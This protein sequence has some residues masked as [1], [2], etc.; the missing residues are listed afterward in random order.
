ME[1]YLGTSKEG[2]GGPSKKKRKETYIGK[3]M[4]TEIYKGLEEPSHQWI[5]CNINPAKVS[6]TIKRQEQRI[7]TRAWKCDNGLVMDTDSCR[8]C[9]EVPEG[10]LHN[11]FWM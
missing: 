7:E 6:A 4:L 10:V 8:L 5:K 2:T 3:K 11:H 9:S 1:Q